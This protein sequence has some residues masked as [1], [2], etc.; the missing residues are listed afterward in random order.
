MY[1]DPRDLKDKEI[2]LRF[3]EEEVRE[4]SE[5][6]KVAHQQ[7]AVLMRELVLEGARR[8]LERLHQ[9]AEEHNRNVA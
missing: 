2:K 4:I 9:E 1:A 6:A 3:N 8:L 7:R 5:A